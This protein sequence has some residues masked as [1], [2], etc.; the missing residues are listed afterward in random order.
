MTAFTIGAWNV[1]KL[2]N[3]AGTDRPERR[4]ALIAN[5]LARYKV[6]IATLSET[7]LAD[8]GHLTGQSAGYT[9]LDVGTTIDSRQKLALTF[10]LVNMLAARAMGST[11]A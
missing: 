8:E 11:T 7:L 10:N 4:T 6:Q 5:E 1:R 3:R 2:L 9:F